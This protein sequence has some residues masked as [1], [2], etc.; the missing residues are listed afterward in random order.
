MP[1]FPVPC[2]LL[3]LFCTT[4]PQAAVEHP[5]SW[6]GPTLDT[7]VPSLLAQHRVAGAAVAV[8]RGGT[9]DWSRG[10][11]L[12]DAARGRQVGNDTRFNIGSVSKPI[13]A[14]GVTALAMTHQIDLDAPVQRYLRRWQLPPSAFDHGSVTV[15][16]VLSHT[17][18]LSVRGYHGVRVE[19]EAMPTLIESLDGYP[20]SDGALRVEREPGSEFVYSSGGYTMLQLLIED[21]TGERFADYMRRSLFAPLRMDH[22]GYDWTPELRAAVATPYNE[23]GRPWPHFVGPEQA[24][25]GV[26]TTVRDLARFVAAAMPGPEGQRPGRGI[27]TADAVAAMV[28]PAAATGGRHGLGYKQFAVPGGSHLVTYDGAN[29]G[30]RAAF[31]MSAGTGDGL[32]ILTNSDAGGRIVAPIVCAWASTTSI[33]MAALC[34]TVRR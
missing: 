3:P 2:A 26:Y 24:S 29:E 4:P 8:V 19:G 23:E 30:W 33:K 25:G 9:L 32:V 20:G 13:T 15:R 21:V 1:R 10:F 34:A 16:R 14:W 11:G 22:T 7:L 28:A 12:A 18:G 31:F 27:L 5:S 17:A 6:L